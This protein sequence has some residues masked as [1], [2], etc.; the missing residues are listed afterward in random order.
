MLSK[1]SKKENLNMSTERKN[2]ITLNLSCPETICKELR[3]LKNV[4]EVKCNQTSTIVYMN[5][6]CDTGKVLE[7]VRNLIKRTI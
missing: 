5:D 1:H 3:R 2:L 7:Q 6:F 4:T